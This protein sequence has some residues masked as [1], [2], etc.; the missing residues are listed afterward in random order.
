MSTVQSNASSAGVPWAWIRAARDIV[1]TEPRRQPDI[2]PVELLPWLYLSDMPSVLRL[3]RLVEMGITA[4]LTTNK[5]ILE[6]DLWTMTAKFAERDIAHWYVGGVDIVGYDMMKYHWDDAAKFI[7]GAL[8]DGTCPKIAVHCAA[9][10]NRSALIAGAA[11]LSFHTDRALS[12]L[13]VIGILKK[14]RGAVLNNVWFIRQ[15][16]EFAQ[17]SNRLGPKPA[18]YS[19]EPLRNSE[20]VF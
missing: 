17:R 7:K 3:D 19:D 4:V 14:Q 1:R 16:A 20:M 2:M 11:M 13:D 6:N 10:T 12:F 15:L 18:G 9:G 8:E 5:V